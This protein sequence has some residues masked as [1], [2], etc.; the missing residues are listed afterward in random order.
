MKTSHKVELNS[1]MIRMS[2]SATQSDIAGLLTDLPMFEDL[3][4]RE[5][6]ILSRHFKLYHVQ[7]GAVLFHEGDARDFMA[8]VVEGAGSWTI[9]FGDAGSDDVIIDDVDVDADCIAVW[10]VAG[11]TDILK[12]GATRPSAIVGDEKLLSRLGTL[13]LP[14]QRGVLGARLAAFAA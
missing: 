14:A 8:I 1:D 11:F 7:P 9:T 2:V 5:I 4:R 6:E 12:G 13:M 10:T 3:E